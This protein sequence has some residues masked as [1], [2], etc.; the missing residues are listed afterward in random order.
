MRVDGRRIPRD[1]GVED[2]RQQHEASDHRQPH[3]R[4]E[5][6]HDRQPAGDGRGDLGLG[7]RG[8][9]GGRERGRERRGR[10]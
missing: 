8:V 4:A 9:G 7:G 3:P 6:V 1:E 2:E 5:R 10:G